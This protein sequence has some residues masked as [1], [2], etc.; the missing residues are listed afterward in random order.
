MDPLLCVLLLCWVSVAMGHDDH[1]HH[2]SLSVDLDAGP[3]NQLRNSQFI[4]NADHISEHLKDKISFNPA[5]ATPQEL[6]F[7]FFKSHDINSDNWLDGLELYLALDHVLMAT[8]DS[9]HTNGELSSDERHAE[10]Q[11]FRSHIVDTVD[12]ILSEDDLNNDGY[13]SYYEFIESRNHNQ[14]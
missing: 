14:D 9:I 10:L 8:E 1:D 6:D 2:E 12:M 3:V 13:L 11:R 5:K 7:H 4:R